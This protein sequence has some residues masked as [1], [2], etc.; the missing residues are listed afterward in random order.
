MATWN[1]L[2]VMP[3]ASVTV[4]STGTVTV[5]PGLPLTFGMK[6]V[7][8]GPPLGAGRQARRQRREVRA[9]S[10]GRSRAGCSSCR[11]PGSTVARDVARSAPGRPAGSRE[12]VVDQA[13]HPLFERDVRRVVRLIAVG[14]A[15]VGGDV[16]GVLSHRGQRLGS[17]RIIEDRQVGDLEDLLGPVRCVVGDRGRQVAQ[18]DRSGRR[19]ELAGLLMVMIAVPGV[20]TLNSA[21]RR[22]SSW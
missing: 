18:R 13:D 22:R 1:P 21:E 6:I 14:V 7:G 20:V 17:R 19:A 12:S 4:I 11:W 9:R 3:A 8:S 10:P 2:T 15:E 5:S 16:D